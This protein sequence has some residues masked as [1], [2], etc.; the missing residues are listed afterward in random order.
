MLLH[1]LGER[2]REKTFVYIKGEQLKFL[3]KTGNSMEKGNV[4]QSLGQ[5][6]RDMHVPT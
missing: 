4:L 2:K 5:K 1:A 3:R 6:E